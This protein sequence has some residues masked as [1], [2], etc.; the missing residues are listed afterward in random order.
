LVHEQETDGFKE[1][2]LEMFTK[3][4]TNG[5]G[6]ISLDELKKGYNTYLLKS[7]DENEIEKA[8]FDADA[9]SSG[10]LDYTEFVQIATDREK[11][12]Q[13]DNLRRAF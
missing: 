7:M 2:L 8:F 1:N 4:D 6:F 9:D 5:D 3:F 13:T 10:K 11:N 12:I